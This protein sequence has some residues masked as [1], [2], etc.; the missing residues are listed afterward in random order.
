MSDTLASRTLDRVA[1]AMRGGPAACLP[2]VVRLISTLSTN[3]VNVSVAELVEVIQQDPVV[4]TKV[5]GAA[6]TLGYNPNGVQVSTV[7]Q[8]VHVIGYERIRTLAMS[9][10]LM[11]H[12]TG[13]QRDLD[14]QE[15][16]ALAL[17]AGCVAQAAAK[18]R[19]LLD[20][21]QAFVCAALRNF[22]RLVL[23]TYLTDEYRAAQEEADVAA[24]DDA[25][26]AHFGLTPLELGRELL[27]AA[28]LPEE[29]MGALR[30][31]PPAALAVLDTAPST[32]M[33]AIA[34]FSARLAALA[35]K[36]NLTAAEFSRASRALAA[37]YESSLPALSEEV[38]DLVAAAETQYTGFART[39]GLKG[40]ANQSL[41]RLRQR[42][43]GVDPSASISSASRPS[44]EPAPKPIAPEPAPMVVPVTPSSRPPLPDASAHPPAPIVADFD[45]L[46]GAAHVAAMLQ[47]PGVS[48]DE[49]KVTILAIVQRGFA[50]TEGLLFTLQPGGAGRLTHGRGAVFSALKETAVIRAEERTVFGV[51]LARH[52]NVFIHCAADPKIAPY[53]PAWWS[54]TQAIGSFVLLPL[55]A[56]R[57]TTG[58]ILV[59]W[60]DPHQ[61]VISAELNKLIRPLLASVSGVE[62]RERAA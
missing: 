46:G 55:G 62:R 12:V 58:L 10:M 7:T 40:M 34:D 54:R 45:W 49:V 14:R 35:L 53:L 11:K 51:C 61:I 2:E 39:F 42:C 1:A 13:G 26:R 19:R 32:Q 23:A 4:F 50:A 37:R 25:W 30:E 17:T 41:I 9:L 60:K 52:E 16:V 36:A 43:A 33:L 59:G 15:A 47:R 28:D 48:R 38:G 20:P 56:P 57:A 44:V 6:N 8:A 29:V 27:K 3:S 24:D 31:L 22:G 21:E 18:S 5:L